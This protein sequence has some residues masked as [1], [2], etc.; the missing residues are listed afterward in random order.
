MARNEIPT[1]CLPPRYL[2]FRR[3]NKKNNFLNN[4]HDKNTLPRF[5]VT[6]SCCTTAAPL[7]A[8]IGR[9]SVSR[10]FD[11]PVSDWFL[12]TPVYAGNTTLLR[13]R[14]VYFVSR[15]RRTRLGCRTRSVLY[16]KWVLSVS[17][18]AV[19]WRKLFWMLERA[20]LRRSWMALSFIARRLGSQPTPYLHINNII[21]RR[22]HELRCYL[23]MLL[24]E[25]DIILVHGR[26]S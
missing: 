17:T 25:Y 11:V 6:C 4:G 15:I 16:A 12:A 13:R 21:L 1:Q 14:V 3:R 19:R 8:V 2:R 10:P 26:N 22:K 9:W 7:T 5:S 23:I 20:T 18:S 24:C